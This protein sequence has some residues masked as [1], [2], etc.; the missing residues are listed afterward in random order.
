V[1]GLF[2][3]FSGTPAASQAATG[4][5]PTGV[6]YWDIGV[7]G[8]SGP[9][10]HEST[11]TLS[12]EASILTSVSGYT[13]GGTGFKINSASN[14]AVVSEY[15]NGS[16]VPPEFGGTGYQVP[17]G[18]SDA[19][20]PNPVFNLTP[21]ATVDEGNNW[22][23]LSWGPLAMT[24]P[25]TNALLGN[26]G[27]TATSPAIGYITP[28]NSAVTYASAPSF[29]FFNTA[30]KT[31]NAVDVGAVEFKAPTVAVARVAPTSLTFS[32]VVGTTSPSQTL[33]LTNSGTAS[34]TGISQTFTGPFSRPGGAPGGTCAGTLNAGT[35]CTINVVFTPTATGA[36][37]GSVAING[38]VL[39]TGSPVTLNGT[40]I[41]AIR[42]A[43]VTPNP[44]AFGNWA[45]GTTSNARTLTVA[46]TGNIALAGGTFTFN[47]GSR[48]SRPGGAAGGTCTANLAVGANCT[49]N[50]V[51]SPNATGSINGT[52]TVAYTGAT[53]TPTPVTLT[54]TGVATRATVSITPNPLTI[55][56]PAG[57]NPRTGTGTVTLTNSATSTSQMTVTGVAVNSPG[58]GLLTWFFNA[59]AGQDTCTGTTLTPGQ[60]CTVGVRFTNVSSASGV[61]R[62]GTIVFTDN[63][64]GSPQTGNL[65]GHAN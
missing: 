55:T 2:N 46:N 16:R 32:A 22:I 5:C 9:A 26:Y 12:P 27:L 35:S 33:T 52:L 61:D 34:L 25:V 43:T 62:L 64:T 39:V 58:G 28:T 38:S 65:I 17:P 42:T 47:T 8:D 44:L 37:T 14:P 29:D 23:N 49:I 30:R 45:T 48:Y 41:A 63:G 13:G 15:C 57:S 54:G 60:S 40:G 6:S 11:V 7:R 59:V 36:V 50:V 53:V 19:T 4:G 24:N 51:F 20:V 10:N 56:L 1:V 18:I 3:A 21:A 31:N